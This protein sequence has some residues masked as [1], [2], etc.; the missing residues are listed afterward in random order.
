MPKK[1]SQ[2]ITLRSFL[3]PVLLSVVVLGSVGLLAEQLA[4]IYRQP[5]TPTTEHA[6]RFPA[7]LAGKQFH[8]PAAAGFHRIDLNQNSLLIASAPKILG[9][10]RIALC[11]QRARN[12]PHSP[13]IPLHIGW[14][15][16]RIQQR[17]EANLT[18]NPPLPAAAG[19]KNPL[20]DDGPGG[21]DAPA[22]VLDTHPAG[23]SPGTNTPLQLIIRDSRPLTGLSDHT[24]NITAGSPP[25]LPFQKEAWLLWDA[26][27]HN[28]SWRHA[29]RV[30]RLPAGGRCREKPGTIRVTVYGLQKNQPTPHT[31]R[32]VYVYPHNGTA[33]SLQVTPGHYTVPAGTTNMLEDAALFS[34]AIA[35]RLIQKGNDGRLHLAPADLGRRVYFARNHNKQLLDNTQDTIW[36]KLPWRAETQAAHRLLY[37]TPVGRHVRQQVNIANARR[38]LAAVRIK[39]ESTDTST[40]AETGHWQA[41]WQGRH[42]PLT[43]TMPLLAN[44]LFS[45]IP[46][47]WQNWQRVKHW[48]DHA[49]ASTPVRFTLPL[50]PATRYHRLRLLVAGQRDIRL[51][52]ATVLSNQRRCLSIPPCKKANTLA[53]ELRLQPT[54]N[55]G[56]LT[57][58]FKPLPSQ[59][60]S[61]LFRHDFAHIQLDRDPIR[62][63]TR[64]P[65]AGR[66]PDET[67]NAE[68]TL[69]DRSGALLWDKNTPTPLALS[70]GFGALIGLHPQHRTA[71]A[72]ILARLGQ[73]GATAI[74]ARLTLDSTLQAAA[75]TA[76][77]KQ[78]PRVS[79]RFGKVDPYQQQ[80]FASLVILDADRGDILAAVSL[81]EPPNNVA[82]ADLR[83]FADARPHRGP[84]Y[85][86][87]WQHDSS[88]LHTPGST[89]KLISALTLERSAEQR[90]E[91]EALLNGLRASEI[92]R[93]PLARRY[94]FDP[95]SNRYPANNPKGLRNF[96]RETLSGQTHDREPRYGLEQALRD[97]LNTWFG[98]LVETTDATLLDDPESSGLAQ[99]RPLTPAALDAVRPLAGVTNLLG[100]ETATALDA[101][102][103]PAGTLQTGDLLLVTPAHLD[104]IANRRQV[105][106]AAVG[107][108]MQVTPLHM[109]QVAATIATQKRIT[110]RLLL[111]LQDNKAEADPPFAPLGI[112]TQR[113]VRGMKR[114]VKDG[115]AHTAFRGKRFNALR[116]KLY[117]KTGTADLRPEKGRPN[118]NNAWLVGWLEPEAITNEQRRL[119]FACVINRSRK[120]G[121]VD[122]GQ[123]VARFLTILQQTAQATRSAASAKPKL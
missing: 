46:Q 96:G 2:D 77:L 117:A 17:I 40:P 93:H 86:W 47:N 101:N 67:L 34:T 41:E 102:L 116:P 109:A 53:Y 25:T 8:I 14:D 89:F 121:G 38:L 73:Y 119:A 13:L 62:W 83:H 113:I 90:P 115:S 39:I 9:Q 20:L 70:L 31:P 49:N 64:T 112:N 57:V 7:T 42:L 50:T 71:V 4:A 122:C 10:A 105:R 80:R 21:T 54:A 23:I 82:W 103:L 120:T 43:S 68:V 19:L 15:W 36:L 51:S 32:R 63:Q 22:V 84:L 3:I 95:N 60:A 27:T 92:S 94:Q 24:F 65:M 59:A 26:D 5:D 118:T 107:F 56:Q 100:F 66:Q 88:G 30:Q 44:G 74:N 6:S 87:A 81:P 99:A 35:T 104:P 91:L 55:A 16:N 78:L 1:P 111:E 33:M 48:P 28:N 98:W 123:V 29:L 97:S 76:L 52:G 18:H 85:W 108:R 45:E 114:V 11:D 69:Q 12:T 61:T 75:R 72:G 110:P 106:Q 37:T 58:E 79:A